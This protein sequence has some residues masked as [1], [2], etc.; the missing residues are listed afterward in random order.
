V[1]N[2]EVILADEPVS[3]LD[4]STQASIL[5]LLTNLQEE[6]GLSIMY[7]SHDLSTVAHLCNEI[8]VMYLGRIVES[9]STSDIITDPHHPY[10]K[11]LIN[12]NPVANPYHEREFTQ[13]PGSTSDPIGLGEGCRFRDRCPERMDICEK[14]PYFVETDDGHHTACHLYYDHE[15]LESDQSKFEKQAMEVE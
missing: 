12:A 1:V 10:T 9:G 13:L 2:P 5:R 6:H 14:T 3:M 11:A 8:N 7:I 15:E 4:V